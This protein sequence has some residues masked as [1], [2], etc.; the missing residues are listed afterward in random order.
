MPK[1]TLGDSAGL[2]NQLSVLLK[3][4]GVDKF[5]LLGVV[6][7]I[8]GGGGGN[9]RRSAGL[10]GLGNGAYCTAGTKITRRYTAHDSSY[11]H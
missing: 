3:E 6:K 1:H 5:V 11:P 7:L 9:R 4:V 8:C 2:T 10:V